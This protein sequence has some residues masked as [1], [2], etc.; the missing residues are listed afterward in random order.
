MA[1]EGGTNGASVRSE[2]RSALAGLGYEPDEV[3]AVLRRLP[4]E[5]EVE[6]MLREALKLLA[7]DR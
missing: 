3:G 2:L 1:F 6:P 4:P 5:G 7:V